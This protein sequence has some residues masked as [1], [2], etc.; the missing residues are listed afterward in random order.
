MNYILFDDKQLRENLKPLTF[1][2]PIGEIRVGIMTIRQKWEHYLKTQ[3]STLSEKYLEAKFPLHREIDNIFINSSV[4]PNKELVDRIKK[5]KKGE[6]LISGNILVA[7]YAFDQWFEDEKVG[8]D[9][10]ENELEMEVEIIAN[11][12]DIFLKNAEQIAADFE[13]ITKGRKS[14]VLDETNAIIGDGK[15]FIEKG[16]NIHHTIFNTTDGPIY[17]GKDAQ[18]MEGSLIRGPFAM[19]EH[20]VVKMHAKI[21]GGCTIGPYSK[22]AGELSN[23][24]IFGYSNKGHDGFLGNSVVAEWCNF[25]AG[26][27]N[28]NLK[29]DYGDIKLW[30][31]AA[32][33]FVSTGLQFCGLI[34][35]DHSKCAIGTTFNTGTVV[36]VNANIFGAGFPRNFIP[37]FS[38]GGTTDYKLRK[39]MKVAEIV[40]GRRDV[41]FDAVEKGIFEHVYNLTSSD[42]YL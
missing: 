38:W 25:G 33:S 3:T 31:Y 14:E 5:L 1:F 20:A 8:D 10:V 42:N 26:S 15:L 27:N 7:L 30:N 22:V 6:T 29:N 24:V 2:R 13:L 41:A 17:I 32:S 19:N 35:G 40:Y 34:M 39:A 9:A 23:V 16:A 21:Y 12:Y 37:S 4:L 36:G 28:S 11:T 18:V